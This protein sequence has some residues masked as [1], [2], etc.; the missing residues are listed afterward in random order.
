MS[1]RQFASIAGYVQSFMLAQKCGPRISEFWLKLT[2]H[3]EE[4]I[5]FVLIVTEAVD[6]L[7]TYNSNNPL[8]Y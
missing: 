4:Q 6:Y 8:K 5:K 3:L 1:F 7:Y 2:F